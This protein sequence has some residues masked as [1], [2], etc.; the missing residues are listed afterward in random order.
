MTPK[1]QSHRAISRVI[2]PKG[3]SQLAESPHV[4]AS[5]GQSYHAERE[6]LIHPHVKDSPLRR[7]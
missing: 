5:K 1:G 6:G 7:E 4:I 3:Q 2:T